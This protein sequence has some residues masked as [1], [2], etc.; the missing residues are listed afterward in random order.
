MAGS[1]ESGTAGTQQRMADL[2]SALWQRHLPEMQAR[3]SRLDR[4]VDAAT[5][6]TLQPS[7]QQE[8]AS[9][10]HKLAGSLGMYGYIHGT[11]LS[12]TLE[13]LLNASKAPNPADLRARTL[14][15][16]RSLPL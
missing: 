4:A 7:L 8:A 9:V 14:E 5:E 13:E 16:R 3:L 11:E 15:L 10:A 6:G 2:M 1:N 12:R